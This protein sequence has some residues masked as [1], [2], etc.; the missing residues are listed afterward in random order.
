[1]NIEVYL[2]CCLLIG[3]VGGTFG[4]FIGMGTGLLSLPFFIH[5]MPALGVPSG[6]LP[7]VV[8]CTATA[9]M[10]V[11]C[12]IACILKY[13][14]NQIHW[15]VVVP[16]I[17]TGILGLII[18]FIIT[19]FIHADSFEKIV[20]AV[21]LLVLISTVFGR[22]LNE[23]QPFPFKSKGMVGISVGILAAVSGLCN[24]LC[25]PLVG[26]KL[27]YKEAIGT[28]LMI[29]TVFL[30]VTSISYIVM[31]CM[32]SKSTLNTQFFGYLHWPSL[33]VVGITSFIGA[34]LIGVRL[35]R[36]CSP[37]WTKRIV[38]VFIAASAFKMLFF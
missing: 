6:I 8:V 13:K 19:H 38:T 14:N 34:K 17:C 30:W 1:M 15:D 11:T 9:C 37:V 16:V 36:V 7:E 20:G 3:L 21:L 26:R 25:L 12:T 24:G 23:A 18:G 29:S 32:H 31:G 35:S 5:F 28:S 22:N 10:A 2:F 33:L 4:A 27:P